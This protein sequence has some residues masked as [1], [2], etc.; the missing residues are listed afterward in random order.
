M[1]ARWVSRREQ[2]RQFHAAL[3]SRR[4]R[5]FEQLRRYADAARRLVREDAAD[6]ADRNG[7]AAHA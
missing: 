1:Y 5:G 2:Q 3:A 6:P 4:R 7:S